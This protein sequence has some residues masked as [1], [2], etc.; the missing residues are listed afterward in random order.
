[1][2]IPVF[3]MD[4][5]IGAFLP[6]IV[7]TYLLASAV[8][9]V[10]AATLTP[11]LAGMM[12]DGWTSPP[13]VRGITKLFDTR[14][15]PR[16]ASTTTAVVVVVVGVVAGAIALPF[17]SRDANPA[18][19]ERNL[20]VEL[21]TA[22]GT[23]LTRMTDLTQSVV[24]AMAGVDGVRTVAA[25][26]GRAITSDEIGNVN[27]AEVWVRLDLGA[28]W[29]DAVNEIENAI[30][31]TAGLVANVTTHSGQRIRDLLG[32]PVDDIAVRVYGESQAVLEEKAAE[33]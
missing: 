17:V 32:Q 20:V 11:A 31:D 15:A 4:G 19:R 6:A 9:L 30:P 14:F 7:S 13:V 3:Y 25:H 2:A 16:I 21:H 27:S 26:I 24:D 8:S 22:A 29:N 10:V 1:V 5:V 28:N 33:I 18:L 23:S 12:I